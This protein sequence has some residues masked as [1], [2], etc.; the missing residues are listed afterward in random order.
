MKPSENCFRAADKTAWLYVGKTAIGTTSDMVTKYLKEKFPD[1]NVT[2]EELHAREV[3]DKNNFKTKSFKVGIDYELLDA[4]QNP[5]TWPENIIVR[6]FRFFR[7]Q[8]SISTNL[9]IS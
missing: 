6:R 2:V 5:N 4:M 1:A 8:Q 3:S 9:K 7:D